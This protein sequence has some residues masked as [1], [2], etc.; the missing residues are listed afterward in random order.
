[1]AHTRAQWSRLHDDGRGFR[2]LGDEE[3]RLLARHAPARAAGGRALDVG[4]GTGELAVFLA[5]MGHTVDAADF[6][7]GALARARAEHADVGAVRWLCLDVEHDSLDGLAEDYDLITMRLAVAFIHDR[8]RVLRRLAARLRKGGALVVMSPVAERTPAERR[9]IALDED[10]LTLLT[11]GFEE[12]GR[13]DTG[14]LAVLVLRAPRASFTAVEKGR[15]EPQTV[16]GAATVVSDDAG[17]VLLGRST[18]GMWE[19]PGGRIETRESATAAAVR[20]LA[21]ETG[22][23][24]CEENACLLMFLHDDVADVRRVTA[25]V[26]VTGWEGTLALPEPHGFLRWE[27]HELPALAGIGPLFAPSAQVLDA[28]WPG[29]LPGLP[30]VRSY[31]LADAP[32]PVPCEPPRAAC[33]RERMAD[34]VGFLSRLPADARDRIP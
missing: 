31:R 11:E 18:G 17:R 2:S 28:V 34:A 26:R 14:S 27:W 16:F 13:H 23:L 20:E 30:S 1:M 6:A 3:K 7:E 25:V 32:P 10:E 4:C 22:L 5:S 24:A 12:S 33:L 21:E 19:L 8:T 9:H 29:L 15:P